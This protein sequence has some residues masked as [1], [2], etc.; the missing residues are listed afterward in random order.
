MNKNTT[1]IFP[2]QFRVRSALRAGISCSILD[3]NC[4]GKDKDGNVVWDNCDHGKAF[5]GASC[6][7]AVDANGGG[8]CYEC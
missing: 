3:T 1:H 2:K 4:K 5:A 6:W 7:S 8:T